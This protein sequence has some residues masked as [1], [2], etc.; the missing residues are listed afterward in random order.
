MVDE[1]STSTALHMAVV[2][3]QEAAA[4]LLLDRGANPNLAD[5]DGVT[6]LMGRL[7]RNAADPAAADGG[8]GRHQRRRAGFRLHRFHFACLATSPTARRRWRA[9]AATR[10]CG[11]RTAMTGRDLAERKQAHRA[12]LERLRSLRP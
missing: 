2:K 7:P 10:P 11:I 6:P 4:R 8:E 3:K 12:V 1:N 5:S 9:P